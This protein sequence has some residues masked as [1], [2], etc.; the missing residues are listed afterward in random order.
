MKELIKETENESKLTQ[1]KY[2]NLLLQEIDSREQGN[3]QLRLEAY[4]MVYE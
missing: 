3:S 1:L 4:L 2:L